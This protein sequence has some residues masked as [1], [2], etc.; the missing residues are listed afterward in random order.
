MF[1]GNYF[2]AFWDSAISVSASNVTDFAT[3]DNVLSSADMYRRFSDAKKIK[4][5]FNIIGQ[6]IE[7]Y[8]TNEIMSLKPQRCWHEHIVYGFSNTCRYISEHCH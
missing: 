8:G 4:N 6:T 1:S 3:D 2:I 5:A 7:P